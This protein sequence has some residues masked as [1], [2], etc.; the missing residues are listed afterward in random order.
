MI[1]KVLEDPDNQL[2]CVNLRANLFGDSGA[3]LITDA[4]KV[5]RFTIVYFYFM[6]IMVSFR[7]TGRKILR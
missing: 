6:F 4:L 2:I 7:L 5:M 1:A 3:K